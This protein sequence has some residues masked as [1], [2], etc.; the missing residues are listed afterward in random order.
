MNRSPRLA[1]AAVVVSLAT[2]LSAL[3]LTLV[4]CEEPRPRRM[5]T[6]F[7]DRFDRRDLGTDWNATGPTWRIVN[8]VV[9]SEHARNH[10]LWLR[11]PLPRDARIEFDAW[12]DS[13]DGDLKVEVFGDG[14]SYARTVSY[15]ATSYVVVFGGWRN[16]FNV[17]AR[18]DEHAPDRRQR[19]EPKVVPRQH[20]H[21]AIERRARVLRWL[22]DGNPMLEWDDPD[23]LAGP[24][25]EHF[26]FNNWDVRVHFDNLV[27][28]PL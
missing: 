18:M 3:T 20:Y 9:Q 10:P 19:T 12:S 14:T 5:N 8:G 27:V 15:T 13:P 21:F 11:R 7:E 4:A 26:A 28:T 17:I 1:Y 22:L 16:N 23:P 6:R 2:A 25:H 24:G